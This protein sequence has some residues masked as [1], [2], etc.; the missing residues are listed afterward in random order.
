MEMIWQIHGTYPPDPAYGHG[1]DTANPC[2]LGVGCQQ[3][4]FD[5]QQRV[6]FDVL[7]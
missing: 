5:I 2:L 1:T 3:F 6:W 4:V 7:F